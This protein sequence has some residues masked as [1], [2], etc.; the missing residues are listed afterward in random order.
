MKRWLGALILVGSAIALIALRTV[1]GADQ[2]CE[3]DV[4]FNLKGTFADC[5][6]REIPRDVAKAEERLLS[7][8]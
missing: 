6:A 8:R 4:S 3:H 2:S 5:E 1:L 7:A